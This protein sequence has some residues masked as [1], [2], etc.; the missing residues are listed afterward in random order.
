MYSCQ[1]PP[2][3]ISDHLLEPTDNPF[4]KDGSKNSKNFKSLTPKTIV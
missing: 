3:H 1:L 2:F 4:F